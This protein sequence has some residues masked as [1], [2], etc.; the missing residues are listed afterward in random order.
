[1]AMRRI[2]ITLLVA[3]SGLVAMTAVLSGCEK[4]PAEPEY[5]N[6]FDPE[7]P[8]GGNPF[9]LTATLS[10]SAI[11]LSWT[12]PQGYGI[13]YYELSHSF[14]FFSDFLPIGSVDHTTQTFGTLRYENA[15]PT[16]THYFRI[17][18]FDETGGFT[19]VTDQTPAARVTPP[20][21][22]VGDGSGQVAARDIIISVAV[23]SGD[24]LRV[25]SNRDFSDEIR[26]A[27]LSPGDPQDVPW[28]LP[29]AESNDTTFTI[30]VLAIMGAAL[31]DTAIVDLDVNFAPPFRVEE[32]PNAV[33]SR[34]QNLII[35]DDGVIQMRFADSEE[36]LADQLW[37]PGGPS[38]SFTLTD[39]ANPQTI[40]GEFEGDFGF[41]SIVSLTVTPD[42]LQEASFN[43]DLPADHI[44]DQS[45]VTVLADA[46][47][48]QMRFSTSLDFAGVPWVPYAAEYDLELGTEPG[49]KDYYCQFRNDWSQ[50]SILTDYVIYLT[51]P[52]E[53]TITAPVEGEQVPSGLG[54]LVR[55]TSTAASGTAAVD[56]VK[57]DAGDGLGFQAATGT[58]NWSFDWSVPG[59]AEETARVIRARAWAAD[60]SVTTSVSVTLLPEDVPK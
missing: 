23:S 17:Q 26:M 7:G 22:A 49:R 21:V 10:D 58:D 35:P 33:A 47:A 38:A 40:W 56:S 14:N 42:L 36:D 46:A 5:N 51:Q 20:L 2:I 15:E 27:V 45:T 54:L 41:N 52:L 29:A 39:S 50:S 1:M 13:S 43:F 9:E 24:S 30:R 16:R 3:V 57:F 19:R 8:D 28:T 59:V 32:N 18:A 11:V 34:V 53:V 25:S 55:G 48:T 12:Q 6:I 60:D 31:S 44:T 37:V 4:S